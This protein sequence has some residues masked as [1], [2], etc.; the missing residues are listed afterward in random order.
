MKLFAESAALAEPEKAKAPETPEQ[1]AERATKEAEKRA[2]RIVRLETELAKL[3]AEQG[4]S[5]DG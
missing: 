1:R 4:R 2:R 3:R 5:L